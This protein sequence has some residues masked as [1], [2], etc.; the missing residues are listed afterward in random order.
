[1]RNN[2][3]YDSGKAGL[4][5]RSEEPPIRCPHRNVVE[6][7]LFRNAEIGIDVAGAV[8]GVV[9]R[10]NRIVDTEGRMEAGLRIGEHVT[11][12]TV[13]D[14]TFEGVKHP[15]VDLRTEAA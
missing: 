15:V 12:L 9:L 10:N 1:M 6:S 8:E 2:R 13:K 7:N 5:F 3:V 4:Y 11:H 14:N